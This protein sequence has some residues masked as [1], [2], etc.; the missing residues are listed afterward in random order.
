MKVRC[1]RSIYN[2]AYP[3]MP[4]ALSPGRPPVSLNHPPGGCSRPHGYSHST[5][6]L[7][8]VHSGQSAAYALFPLHKKETHT[9]EGLPA[10]RSHKAFYVRTPSQSLYH[11]SFPATHFSADCQNV[12]K[13]IPY[14]GYQPYKTTD[15]IRAAT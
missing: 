6:S 14:Y 2:P 5:L 1:P 12:W 4:Y 11:K 3:R 15:T 13:E 10:C 9:V 7:P 8:P